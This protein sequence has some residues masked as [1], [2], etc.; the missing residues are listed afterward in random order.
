MNT[1]M[2]N[3]DPHAIGWLSGLFTFVVMSLVP[4]HRW[5]WTALRVLVL[6]YSAFCF[7]AM[8]KPKDVKVLPWILHG[9]ANGIRKSARG[10]V[11]FVRNLSSNKDYKVSEI[12][13]DVASD[14]YENDSTML[15]MVAFVAL[16][17][18]LA[19]FKVWRVLTTRWATSV[20]ADAENAEKAPA[21]ADAE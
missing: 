10:V 3:N 12:I 13:R 14:A 7:F 21:P 1:N 8:P 20:S 2:N 15:N 5:W 4:V 17:P 16:V 19:V 11:A 9:F 18:V 6:A